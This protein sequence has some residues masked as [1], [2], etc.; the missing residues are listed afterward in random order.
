[1]CQAE[2]PGAVRLRRG[3][4]WPP[5]GVGTPWPRGHA[6]SNNGWSGP[7]TALQ[8]HFVRRHSACGSSISEAGPQSYSHLSGSRARRTAPCDGLVF[9]RLSFKKCCVSAKHSRR[10][11]GM[12]Q[13]QRLLAWCVPAVQLPQSHVTYVTI[14]S[15]PDRG[16]DA[17]TRSGYTTW[18]PVTARCMSSQC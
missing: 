11:L 9:V 13:R 4:L 16:R 14:K 2:S 17:W 12:L 10:C 3:H 1:M 7:V 18:A 5:A 15:P 6:K 8:G